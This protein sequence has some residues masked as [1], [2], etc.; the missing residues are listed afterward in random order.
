MRVGGIWTTGWNNETPFRPVD[1]RIM[2]RIPVI[3]V[4]TRIMK[5]QE[6]CVTNMLTLLI[7]GRSTSVLILTQKTEKN[8]EQQQRRQIEL[9]AHCEYTYV[10]LP[11]NPEGRVWDDAFWVCREI[12]TSPEPRKMI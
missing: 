9:Y 1:T 4:N 11:V 7:F 12:S 10:N 6:W 8:S 2:T 5:S 3:T